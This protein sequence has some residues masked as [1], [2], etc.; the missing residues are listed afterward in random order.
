MSHTWLNL[1]SGQCTWDFVRSPRVRKCLYRGDR[2]EEEERKRRREKKSVF[3]HTQCV[4]VC[5]CVYACAYT[6]V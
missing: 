1:L 6:Y 4:Y 5:V 2:E 3:L